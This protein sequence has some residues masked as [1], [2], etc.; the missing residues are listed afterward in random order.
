MKAKSFLVHIWHC[1][2]K[3]TQKAHL[4]THIKSIHEGQKFPCSQCE[5]KS[6]KKT[7]LQK[8]VKSVHGEDKSKEDLKTMKTESSSDY[9]TPMGEYFENDI[10]SEL[11]SV[12]EL[13]N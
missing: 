4:R 5:Y 1:E 12:I 3:A 10:K 8:H 9:D 6:T 11:D 13:E 7:L 2:Y